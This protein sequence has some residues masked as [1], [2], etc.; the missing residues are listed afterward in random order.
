MAS[1]ATDR[2]Q[3][4]QTLVARIGSSTDRSEWLHRFVEGLDTDDI[5][6]LKHILESK[7]LQSDPLADKARLPDD[8][9][10]RIIMFLSPKDI[11]RAQMVSRRWLAVFRH[12]EY[13]R[14]FFRR[15]FSLKDPPLL[16]EA[17]LAA[18]QGANTY[19]IAELK[20]DHI[21]RFQE[22]RPC[23]DSIILREFERPR[24]TAHSDMLAFVWDDRTR[25]S[26]MFLRKKNEAFTVRV[27]GHHKV[28]NLLLG[29]ELMVASTA[30]R[31]IP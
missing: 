15:W 20:M 27:P 25:I 28:E 6:I 1:Q 29:D 12:P 7:T 14:P 23:S 13:L 31:W 26:V 16:G 10:S 19:A 17:A 8:V 2:D 21:K 22:L 11:C 3:G 18:D 9:L 5:R 4:D 30:T 24:C